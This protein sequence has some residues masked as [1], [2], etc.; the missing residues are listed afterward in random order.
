MSTPT[1]PDTS[2][3]AQ[4][5]KES[6][7]SAKY[8]ATT[9]GIF[10][11]IALVAFET[12]AVT[13]IMPTLSA[14]LD[15][16]ELYALGFAAPLASGVVGMVAAGMWSDRRG[17]ATPLFVGLGFFAVGLTIAGLAPTM[18][19]FVLARVLQGLGGGAAMVVIYVVVGLIY[20]ARLQPSLFAALAAAWVLP[21]LF[22][23]L[24]AATI[25]DAFGWRWV[26]LGT[27]FIV[28]A[29]TLLLVPRM[30]GLPRPQEDP[31][32][33]AWAPLMWAVVAAA[34]VLG[35][36]LVGDN[37]LISLACI[38]LVVVALAKLLPAGSLVL[39]KGLPSVISTRGF[40]A[41]S[42]FTAEAYIVLTLEE[43]WGATPTQAGLALTAVGIIW[44]AASWLQSKRVHLSHTAAMVYGTFFIVLGLGLLTAT[45]W[46]G[47]HPLL[48]GAVY[49]AAG[50][51]MGFS[52]SRTSVAMLHHSTDADRGNNS[53]ALNAADS[54]GAALA[55]AIV[56]LVFS[57]LE[58][59]GIDPFGPVYAIA[60]FIALLGLHSA[61]RTDTPVGISTSE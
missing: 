29:M 27:V 15:G 56:G 54:V 52:Y 38:A 34:A 21:A 39:R 44:A 53:A 8:L 14:A 55:V 60:T 13:T 1:S 17:A 20:P 41:A 6:V 61:S 40:L 36:R 19:L 30:R 3:A 47:L 57:A 28:A 46:L 12:L 24:L 33:A 58:S 32:K 25:A 59:A 18:E 4:G 10:S 45:I 22:G 49:V 9:I 23:P 42:F 26:F 7:L 5:P 48:A 50:A 11:I 35:V 37:T 31:G 16:R 2:P 43:K 51:G